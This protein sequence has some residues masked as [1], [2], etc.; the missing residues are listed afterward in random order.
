VLGTS[1][2]RARPRIGYVPQHASIDVSVPATALDVVLLGRLRSSS[3]GPRFAESHRR[4]A[5]ESLARVGAGALAGRPLRALSGGQRQ[6]VLIARALVADAE[7]LLLDEPTAGVDA[8]G[9]RDLIGLLQRLREQLSVVMVSH[10]LALVSERFDR[11]V[12]VVG[13]TVQVGGAGGSEATPAGAKR[14]TP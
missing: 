14:A 13:G 5:F 8:Q 6:R 9:E 7:L 1:P 11:V 10:D 2:L 3:W 12:V 4:R